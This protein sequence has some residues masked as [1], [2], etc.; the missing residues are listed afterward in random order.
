MQYEILFSKTGMLQ[1]THLRRMR[2]ASSCP[3]LAAWVRS[4]YYYETCS[5]LQ[6]VPQLKL[7]LLQCFK[8]HR[9]LWHNA[10]SQDLTWCKAVKPSELYEFTSIS[11]CLWSSFFSLWCLPSAAKSSS[12][13]MCFS[14]PLLDLCLFRA[15]P[16]SRFRASCNPLS[17]SSSW[18]ILARMLS[19]C[20]PSSR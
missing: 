5:A 18:S 6:T 14:L 11:G 3:N 8:G 1:E 4:S 17:S 10:R 16:S 15:D 20:S 2:T 7:H 13:K 9:W 12:L 19:V